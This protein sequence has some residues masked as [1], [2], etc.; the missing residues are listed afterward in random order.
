MIRENSY[1]FL[2]KQEFVSKR[3]EQTGEENPHI[4]VKQIETSLYAQNVKLGDCV[5]FFLRDF[6]VGDMKNGKI[7]ISAFKRN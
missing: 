3:C 1:N 4:I 5:C 2:L 6:H 7:Y